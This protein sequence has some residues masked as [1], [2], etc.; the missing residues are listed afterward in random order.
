MAPQQPGKVKKDLYFVNYYSLPQGKSCK[1]I[2]DSLSCLRCGRTFHKSHGL[3]KHLRIAHVGLRNVVPD[4]QRKAITKKKRY[5]TI[6]KSSH[7]VRR[8]HQVI[9][10][11]DI[12]VWQTLAVQ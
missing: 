1:T 9:D 7:N 8:H 3:A 10:I 6:R 4:G 12:E 11:D 5:D 2:Y